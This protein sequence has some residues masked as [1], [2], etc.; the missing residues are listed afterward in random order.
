M[1]WAVNGKEVVGIERE[2]DDMKWKKDDM[3][4]GFEDGMGLGSRWRLSIN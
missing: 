4:R 1:C 2:W 3:G